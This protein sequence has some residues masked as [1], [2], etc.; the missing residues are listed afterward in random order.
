VNESNG[1]Q[2]FRYRATPSVRLC[3]PLRI[4]QLHACACLKILSVQSVLSFGYAVLCCAVL[5]SG[6]PVLSCCV[7]E[8]C[9]ALLVHETKVRHFGYLTRRGYGA[10]VNH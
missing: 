5:P 8:T 9:F 2:K 3:F 6:L 1:G 10:L 7:S 4:R